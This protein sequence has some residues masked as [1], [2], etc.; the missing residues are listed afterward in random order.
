MS[1][2]VPVKSKVKISQ[3]FV[4][5]SECMNFDRSKAILELKRWKSVVKSFGQ[6]QS[7]DASGQNYDLH[8]RL[9]T[10]AN[11]P[12]HLPEYEK[13]I[14]SEKTTKFCKIVTLLLTGTTYVGQR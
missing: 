10:P 2:V 11:M 9:T 12:N 7:L 4:V 3:N 6:V 13:F 8:G 14:Y 1:Y 5:F